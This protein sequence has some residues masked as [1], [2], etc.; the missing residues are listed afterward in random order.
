MKTT[1][2]YSEKMPRL[3][4]KNLALRGIEAI[5]EMTSDELRLPNGFPPASTFGLHPSHFVN[6]LP[7]QL[8]YSTQIPVCRVEKLGIAEHYENN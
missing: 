1:A 3:A 4:V 6:V 7:G 8:F 5:R 2:H